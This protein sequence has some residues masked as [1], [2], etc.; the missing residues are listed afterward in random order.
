M[1]ENPELWQ[2]NKTTSTGEY[3][4]SRGLPN[5]PDILTRQMA[6]PVA[7]WTADGSA[8]VLF[9]D[10]SESS[11]P[12]DNP[13]AIVRTFARDGEKWIAHRRFVGFGWSY[14]PIF[15]PR[16]AEENVL[17]EVGRRVA[18]EPVAPGFPAVVVAGCA[19]PDVTQIAVVQGDREVRRELASHF[20]VWIVCMDTVV[21]YE[22]R[23]LNDNG[24]VLGRIREGTTSLIDWYMQNFRSPPRE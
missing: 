1:N 22:I 20:G 11:G 12:G 2:P 14:D 23:A 18:V 4:L 13:M 17:A 21:P 9:L 7:H 5:L 24:D 15:R 3:V 8:V 6:I 16:D 10:F 19:A